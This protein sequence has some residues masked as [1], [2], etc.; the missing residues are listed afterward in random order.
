MTGSE[1][2]M[3]KNK[4]VYKLKGIPHIYWINLDSDTHRRKYMEQQFNYWEIENHIR[5]SG[6][7]GREDDVCQFLSGR[8]PDNMTQGEIGCCMTHLKAIRHFYENMNEDY[9]LILEDDVMFDT[10]KYWNFTWRDFTS[11]L[12]FNLISL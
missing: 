10:V 8:A 7:D 11:R 12:L 5:I 9:V 3:D 4:S 1:L 2:V 6:Y